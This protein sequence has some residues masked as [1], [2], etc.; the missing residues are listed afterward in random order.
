MHFKESDR[1]R[2][3]NDPGRVDLVH[4]YQGQFFLNESPFSFNAIRS[5]GKVEGPTP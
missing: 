3:E 1:N 2:F 4:E 5:L